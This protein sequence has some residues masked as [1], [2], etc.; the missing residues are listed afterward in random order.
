VHVGD[1]LGLYFPESETALPLWCLWF[2]SGSYPNWH[3][4]N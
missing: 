3:Q 2:D 1:V 4:P